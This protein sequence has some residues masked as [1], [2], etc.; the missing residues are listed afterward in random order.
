MLGGNPGIREPGVH[1]ARGI[2]TGVEHRVEDRA[3]G[4]VAR[5]GSP[6]RDVFH[7]TLAGI[8]VEAELRCVSLERQRKVGQ[9]LDAALH[10]A[11]LGDH[12]VAVRLGEDARH[13]LIQ[14]VR[15]VLVL[16]TT[17]ESE[18]ARLVFVALFQS[19][20][21][22]MQGLSLGR[23]NAQRVEFVE[24]VRHARNGIHRRHIAT[25]VPAI[26]AHIEGFISFRSRC[27]DNRSRRF[28]TVMDAAVTFGVLFQEGTGILAPGRR[29]EQQDCR[30]EEE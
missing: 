19:F 5:R 17:P 6:G 7:E 23:K 9:A 13:A 1:R 22:L 12:A 18:V 4:T 28:V 14:S 2:E 16:A 30:K 29:A 3:V 15:D 24:Q 25:A 20:E 27:V 21:R 26:V 10:V 8:D 11:R